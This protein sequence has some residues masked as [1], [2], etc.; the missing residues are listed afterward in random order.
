MPL[1]NV[2]PPHFHRFGRDGIARTVA[3]LYEKLP[4]EVSILVRDRKIYLDMPI[5]RVLAKAAGQIWRDELEALAQHDPAPCPCGC[6][7]DLVLGV[8]KGKLPH[9]GFLTEDELTELY[10]Y[11]HF[12][13]QG[14]INT[15]NMLISLVKKIMVRTGL[16]L[17][18]THNRVREIE[19]HLQDLI[20]GYLPS[21]LTFNE[22]KFIEATAKTADRDEDF[23]HT[24]LIKIAL[25]VSQRVGFEKAFAAVYAYGYFVRRHAV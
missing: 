11:A 25:E 14:A 20:K 22:Y 9:D 15:G 19:S 16:G 5:S 6:G 17:A 12:S 13:H 7:A 18:D 3:Y 1:V 4:R 23:F 10:A 24:E 8:C 2:T 21:P